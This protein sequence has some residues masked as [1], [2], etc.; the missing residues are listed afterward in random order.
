MIRIPT[1]SLEILYRV[2]R[3]VAAAPTPPTEAELLEVSGLESMEK[4]ERIR[5]AVRAK[6]CYSTSVLM[7]DEKGTLEEILPCPNS[8]DE[9]QD[10]RLD[11]S[12][13]LDRLHLMLPHLSEEEMEVIELRYLNE[14]PNTEIARM[15]GCNT[16]RV[17]QVAKKALYKLRRLTQIEDSQQEIQISLF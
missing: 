14:L 15:M 6:R 8:H 10:E 13:Q 4:F 1:N 12:L 3:H 5:S 17:S 11:L 16:D 9:I 2:Q 7:P